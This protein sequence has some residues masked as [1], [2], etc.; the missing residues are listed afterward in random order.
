MTWSPS[1]RQAKSRLI[2]T[3]PAGKIGSWTC[4]IGPLF[5]PNDPSLPTQNQHQEVSFSFRD[6]P[7][8]PLEVRMSEAKQHFANLSAQKQ[9]IEGNLGFE[10]D[11]Q[12]L[13][14]AKACRIAT[15]YP[16]ASI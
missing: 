11:W 15:W 16:H 9:E 10:L 6:L 7:V 5:N 12:A 13:P 1:H 2:S 3:L 8:Q 14:D 4:G